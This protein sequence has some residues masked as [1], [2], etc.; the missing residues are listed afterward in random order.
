MKVTNENQIEEAKD[1]IRR[2]AL[3][4]DDSMFKGLVC[5]GALG[6]KRTAGALDNATGAQAQK[7]FA[8]AAQLTLKGGSPKKAKNM[9]LTL[10][11]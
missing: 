8:A 9:R 2:G 1:K 7:S 11:G 3:G 10:R 4:Y 5:T 6:V